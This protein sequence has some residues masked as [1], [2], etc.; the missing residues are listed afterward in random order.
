[1]RPIMCYIVKPVSVVAGAH[2]PRPLGAE[3]VDRGLVSEEDVDWALARRARDRV[4]AGQHPRGGRDG[5]PDRPLPCAVRDVGLLV[6]RPHRRP[7]RPGLLQDVDPRR[8]VAELWFPVRVEPD[9]RIVVATALR[10]TPERL[11][12]IGRDPRRAGRPGRDE[13]VGHPPGRRPVLR[14]RDARRGRPRPVAPRPRPLRVPGAEPVAADRHRRHPGRARRRARPGADRHRGRPLGHRRRRLPRLGRLQVRHRAWSARATK[15]SSRS[16]REEVAALDDTELPLYTILVP[17][18]HEAN[19]VGAADGQPRP[20]RLPEGEA[21]DLAPAR[22]RRRRDPPGR[23]GRPPAGDRHD[24]HRPARPPADEAEGVQ[25]RALPR[26]RRVP[27]HLRRRGPAGP[28]AAEGRGRRVPPERRA[29]RLRAG[30][31]QLLQ[32]R[33]ERAHPALHARV[34]VLVRLHA[35]RAS[36]RCTCRSRSAARRTTSAPKPSDS[37]AAGTRS[38]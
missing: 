1:M 32:R 11:R 17:V 21:R 5:A 7:D 3:L 12:T 2:T 13:R 36:K 28:P 35:A 10:P 23:H 33:G 22:S 19:V 38:T 20:A 24:R 14:R 25:R 30:R 8:L 37:S 6:R 27:R 34:L 4:D 29:Q 31:A 15:P 9:G 26:P 18:Y 16:R